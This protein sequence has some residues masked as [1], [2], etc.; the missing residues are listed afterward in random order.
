MS[1]AICGASPPR[2]SLCSCGLR[3]CANLPDGFGKCRPLLLAV[4]P[5]GLGFDHALQPVGERAAIFLR[6]A[7][8][9]RFDDGLTRTFIAISRLSNFGFFIPTF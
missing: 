7:L 9:R 2:I 5:R 8:S 6:Q 3:S 4:L 1:A